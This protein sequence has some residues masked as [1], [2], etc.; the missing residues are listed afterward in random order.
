MNRPARDFVSSV[1]SEK[2]RFFV[3]A[4]FVASVFLM[5]GGSRD[6]ISSLA[7]LRPL[8]V[9]AAAY[10]IAV[11]VRGDFTRLGMPFYLLV[12]LAF[13][14]FIQL[15]PLPPAIWTALP[16]R[17]IHAELAAIAGFDQPWRP[18]SLS[19]SKTANSLF[20]LVVPLAAM[21]LLA[22]QTEERRARVIPLLIVCA[23]ISAMVGLAQLI[24]LGGKALYPYR[25]SNFGFPAGLFSNSNHQGVL[26]ALTIPVIVA[27]FANSALSKRKPDGLAV[28]ALLSSA[29]LMPVILLSGSRMALGL[30]VIAIA[31]SFA[32]LFWIYRYRERRSL[33]VPRLLSPIGGLILAVPLVLV[34]AFA[35][36]SFSRSTILDDVFVQTDYQESRL[37]LL[38]KLAEMAWEFAPFGAGF[39]SFEHVYRQFEPREFLSTS[40]LNQAHNDWMQI[41][42]EGGLPALAIVVLLIGWL[43]VKTFSL[44]RASHLPTIHRM[45][46]WL[47]LSALSII[48]L[49][50]A[51][52]YPLRVPV[53]AMIFAIFCVYPFQFEIDRSRRRASEPLNS[54]VSS[55]L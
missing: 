23:V 4:A 6:D 47:A 12:A 15:I 44:L 28:I 48:L 37:G 34:A 19:P 17:E 20:S 41:V 38:P 9:F 52:D 36:L 40:Y 53:M 7:I 46:S 2:A 14:I 49:S 25:I 54:R 29:L 18:L 3:F 16:G 39:G 33:S 11:S 45:R 5:G 43:A 55:G 8:A 35:T 32:F 21:L 50:S 42:I 1:T 22:V 26:L 27:F 24:G 10:A 51:V 30:T 13:W 31:V